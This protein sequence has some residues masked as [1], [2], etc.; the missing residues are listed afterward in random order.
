MVMAAHEEA[1]KFFAGCCKNG[2]YDNMKTAVKKILIGKDRIFNEKFAQMA[3][4]YLFEPVAC[5]P[6]S[7]W[8]KGRV[9]KQVGDNRRNF[10]TPILQRREL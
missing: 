6:S 5:T 4:H 8:E 10:F 9:E 2:I 3:S 1:F 7:G